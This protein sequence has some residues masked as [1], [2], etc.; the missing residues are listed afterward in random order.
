[1]A[2][3]ERKKPVRRRNTTVNLDTLGLEMGNRPP[4]ALDVEEA[5]LGALLIEPNCIDEAMDELSPKCFYSE[6]HRMIFESMRSLV[7]EHVALDLLSVSQ[8]LKANGNLEAVGGT[9]ALVQLS[10]KIGAAAHIEYYI[11]ILK[12]KCIQRELITASYE[13]LKSSYDESVN[14]DELVDSAQSKVY[15]AIQNNVKKDV[16]EIGKVINDALDDLQK[17]QDSS[18]YS[19]VPS[20]FPSVDNITLG[21]QPSDLIILAARPSVGKTAFVVNVARNAAVDFNMPVAIFSL[22][23]PAKQ[24]ANRMMVSETGLSAE[25]IKGGVKLQDWEWQQL[26]IQLKRLTKAPIYIDDTPSLPVMEFRSKVKRLVKQKGV[27]LVVV[28]Y[29]QLMQ[30]PSELR[31]MREQE[32]AAISRTLKATAKEMDVPIIALSQLSR[33]SENRQ[34]SNRRPQLS[35]LRESGSIEQDA[36]MVIFIHRYDYQGLSE[37]PDDVG[38]TQII[39]AKHRN[40]AIADIDMRF[41][42]D[43]VRF[44][45]ESES[46]VS[47][48]AELTGAS[49]PQGYV[50]IASMGVDDMPPFSGAQTSGGEFGMNDEFR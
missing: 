47:Q 21:W 41:R 22:E 34:G 16:Q 46:L 5:V 23:M 37:N 9:V 15:A 33:Q 26:D 11:R 29:L 10:Q 40:G 28:D 7:N 14:V 1:M 3:D 42:A 18:G 8:K 24:L 43:E 44:V 6:K 30:G 35:D 27:R 32:V 13:I 39:I 38:R 12:Q 50:P 20:G 4:Q 31:G 17:R 25:K 45:D 2:D 49:V 36:D 48:A 19:G